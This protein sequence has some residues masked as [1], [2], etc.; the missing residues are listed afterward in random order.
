VRLTLD[1]RI[2][3]PK[4]DILLPRPVDAL[5]LANVRLLLDPTEQGFAL[6]AR[7]G[8]ALGGWTG[9]GALLLPPGAPARLAVARL[10]VAGMTATGELV[11]GEGGFDGE[12][13]VSGAGVSGSL[14]FDRPGKVQRIA[15]NLDAREARIATAPELLVGRGALDGEFLLAPDGVASDLT[16]TARGLRRGNLALAQLAASATLR[17]GRG[18]AKAAF[19]GSRGRAFDLSLI[20][21]VAP[22]GL[23]VSGG[24]TIDRKP[25]RTEGAARIARENGG[26][27]LRPAT[28]GYAGGRMTLAGLFGAP[29]VELDASLTA[30]PLTVFEIVKP[31][32][33]L[34]GSATGR[35]SY[36][37]P[38]A[39]VPSGSADLTVRGLSRSGLVLSSRPIDLG[40]KAVLDG[41]RAGVRAVAASD[42][43]MIGRAQ[44]RLAPLAPG[45]DLATRL[46][47]APMIAQLRY[48]G[49]ADT[50][51]R[52]SGIEQFD[53]SGPVAVAA[54]VRGTIDDPLIRGSLRTENARLESG[55]SG[56]VLTGIKASGRF[57]GSRLAIDS[58]RAT[59]GQ[60][61]SVT[62]S[63]LFDFAA[64]RGVGMDLRVQADK[65]VLINRDDLGATVT[66]PLTIRSDG[67]G[68]VIAGE[69][70]L[71]R[72]RYRLGRARAALAVPRLKV[73]EL[74]RPAGFAA[75]ERPAG[76]WRLDL[77]ATARNR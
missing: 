21:D 31:G 22:D 57:A 25:I 8:S 13:R 77:K 9:D 63:G 20:A 55:T 40:L 68:G 75:P 43:R 41:E 2:N 36:R 18:Q 74:N 38:L 49:P 3:R 37:A 34:G 42:G 60:G 48:A 69:V 27:R 4:L 73:T 32:L 15:V 45:A 28:L 58:F 30:I 10:G 19:A 46:Q 61:G 67:Y 35:V 56:T 6:R 7:G 14:G 50:L 44:A 52:L 33:G 23:S 47:R 39:G 53:L 26:W 54:D 24:G 71:D 51:W 62:G 11:S 1:G 64:A 65:A 17:D 16:V 59:A 70:A 29:D 72:S 5:G 76:P 12:L 66:G